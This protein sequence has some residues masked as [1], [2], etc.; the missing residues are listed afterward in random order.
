MSVSVRGAGSGGPRAVG[1]SGT[2][3]TKKKE[4]VCVLG[5]LGNVVRVERELSRTKAKFVREKWINK[6]GDRVRW[7]FSHYYFTDRYLQSCA[8]VK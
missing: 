5:Y 7:C 4:C 3:A 8:G 6:R 1:G 2:T